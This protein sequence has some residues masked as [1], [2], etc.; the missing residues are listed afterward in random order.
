[1]G[2][3]IVDGEVIV[4]H[5]ENAHLN[6]GING[7]PT[8]IPFRGMTVH[9]VFQRLFHSAKEARDRHTRSLGD[10]C[11]LI[12]ALKGK[13]GLSVSITSIKLLNASIPVLVD[14]ISA[15]VF[16]KVDVVVP[17]P[18]SSDLA[19]ILARRIARRNSL[20]MRT[21]LLVKSSNL[22][23]SVRAKA[24]TAPGNRALSYG[25]ANELKVIVRNLHR[26]AA[27]PYAAKEVKTRF[28]K[29]FDP[30]KLSPA[31]EQYP[32]GTRF[33]LVDDLMATGET[34]LAAQELLTGAGGAEALHAVTW[35][36]PVRAPA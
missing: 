7:N 35:F 27:A 5:H 16:D 12:Y 25:E 19:K 32:E 21:D 18:S 28:R 3:K 23:A 11:P 33:L 1:M 8:E 15:K 31:V 20:V 26:T 36:S 30:L 13:D 14:T 34:L 24:L 17:M 10:N 9:C 4:D 29:Y 2:L 22:Q 6:T